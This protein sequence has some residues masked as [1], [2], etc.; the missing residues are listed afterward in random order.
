MIT[1][2]CLLQT[3]SP[4]NFTH[5]HLLSS[6]LPP[7]TALRFPRL[8]LL[9]LNSLGLSDLS[10]T[11]YLNDC[12]FRKEMAPRVASKTAPAKAP[13]HPPWVEMIKVRYMVISPLFSL[14]RFDN[15]FPHVICAVSRRCTHNFQ[16]GT[17]WVDPGGP[18]TLDHHPSP[19][20]R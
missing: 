14:S 9:A 17:S 6:T 10:R 4:R 8:H 13:T 3:R 18:C 7:S 2:S 1:W 11:S 20:V 16:S 5:S 19:S 12:K 15:V